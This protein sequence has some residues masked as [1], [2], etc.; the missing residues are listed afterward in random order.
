MFSVWLKNSTSR[1]CEVRTTATTVEDSTSFDSGMVKGYPAPDLVMF[2]CP[3]YHMSYH[4]THP[5][6]ITRCSFPCSPHLSC[7]LYFKVQEKIQLQ[8]DS[9]GWLDHFLRILKCFQCFFQKVD[10]NDIYG[11][12]DTM[13]EMNDY[14]TVQDTNDY[15]GK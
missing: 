8:K 13:G 11:T 12:Y 1:D 9:K 5:D 4:T 3:S 2:T 14:S 6:D 15:Y 10:I 7:H